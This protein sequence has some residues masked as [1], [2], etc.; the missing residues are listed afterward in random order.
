M[1]FQVTYFPHW[2]HILGTLSTPQSNLLW[3]AIFRWQTLAT[4]TTMPTKYLRAI[5]DRFKHE[6]SEYRAKTPAPTIDQLSPNQR[7]KLDHYIQSLID[8]KPCIDQISDATALTPARTIEI[9]PTLIRT[10]PPRYIAT[11]TFDAFIEYIQTLHTH[12]KSYP[13]PLPPPLSV[14]LTLENN[15]DDSSLITRRIFYP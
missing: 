6:I 9:L 5:Y 4:D 1:K 2:I 3:E 14:A 8:D 13:Q 7:G 10:Y 12:L 11:M 15:P